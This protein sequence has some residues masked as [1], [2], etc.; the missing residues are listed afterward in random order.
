MSLIPANNGVKNSEYAV[1][2][3]KDFAIRSRDLQGR[4][5]FGGNDEMNPDMETFPY[6][7]VAPS[8]ILI[9]PN[10][11]GKS[12]YSFIEAS[13][14]VTIADKLKSGKDNELQTVSDI[15]EILMALV[16]ELGSHPYYVDNQMKLVGDVNLVTTLEQDDAIVSKVTA[17]I[18][19]RYPFKYQYCNQ[20]VDNI[21]FY[22]S[23]T[24]D[25][26]TSVTQS[27]CTIIEDCPVIL[28]IDLTLINL[29]DQIDNIVCET[30]SIIYINSLSDFPAPSAS[31]ITLQANKTY[32]ITQAVDLDGN[33]L[34]TSGVCNLFGLSSEVSFLTSTGLGVG[35]PLITSEWTIVIE[36]LSIKD[37]DTAVYIDGNS[38]L[39]ALDWKAVNFID[40]PN[41][42]TIDTCDNFIFDTSAFL[43][44]QGLK[45]TGTIGTIALN[46]SLFRGLGS[47]GNI[48]ELDASCIITRRFRIIYSSIIV[49]F[50]TTGI[51]V[52]ASANIPI[53]AY[54]LD[55]VNFS[56]GGPTYL[57]GV[58]NT[59]NKA[60]FINC[61]G[62]TNTAVN[63]QLYMQGNA[64]A[65]VIAGTNTFV[66]IAGT[67]TASPDNSKFSH[68]NNRLTCDA[69][70][71]RK[72]LIQANLAFDSSANNV[73]EF[74]F[75]DSQISTI[76]V[77]SRTKSTA[78]AAGRA[79][80]VSLFCIVEMGAGDYIEVHAAN[81]S[82]IN[83]ITVEQLN[84]AITEIK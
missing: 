81:T 76:R 68:S 41:V 22:P 57:A 13:Y 58:D 7:Y 56:G 45:F 9:S 25:I 19:L 67:T 44:A 6:M 11:D 83:N 34:E 64:T 39:V 79:E 72:Y 40:V 32:I 47:A 55:T 27:I 33:R 73:C 36:K 18:T 82:A 50:G 12:G 21:P 8:D 62:I 10:L 78:N 30:N 75:Y 1:A 52:N 63:G 37:V 35:V 2:I 3:F 28:T 71:S 16:A 60:L 23:I 51:D 29:Q 54:I 61:V 20:P 84:F 42:G 43:G 74:G 70:I 59:S 49:F 38:R 65:T 53:E 77:P 17:Q 31:V 4:F 46:N 5:R 15:Q 26:F 48:I 24:T 69:V 14:D 66:K 80:G